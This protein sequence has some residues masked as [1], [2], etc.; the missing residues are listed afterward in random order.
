M[1]L[2]K[3]EHIHMLK[4]TFHRMN[5]QFNKIANCGVNKT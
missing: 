4:E 3:T 2:K 5:V 1:G